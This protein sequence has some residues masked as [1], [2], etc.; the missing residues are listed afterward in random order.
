[1]MSYVI[2]LAD[3]TGVDL[4]TAFLAKLEKNRAK[5]PADVVRGSATKYTELAVTAP[6]PALPER[7]SEDSNTAGDP[8]TGGARREGEGEWGTPQWVNDAYARAA[9]RVKGP[10]PQQQQAPPP[11]PPPPPQPRSACA[12][13][14]RGKVACPDP[15]A[16]RRSPRRRRSGLRR[17]QR[18]RPPPTDG[19]P[20]PAPAPRRPCPPRP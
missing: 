16:A 20:A 14:A 8:E 12:E 17:A 4:P 3:V 19:M 15:R 10:P 2:R 9:A 1:V 13:R 7:G 18:P 11:S 6:A 5:Y